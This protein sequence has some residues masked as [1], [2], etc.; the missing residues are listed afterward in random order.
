M[1]YILSVILG[2]ML[3]FGTAIAVTLLTQ[4]VPVVTA[5]SIISTTCIDGAHPLTLSPTGYIEGQTTYIRMTCTVDSKGY[6]AKGAI[7]GTPTF[8]LPSQITQLWSYT[9]GT[10][11]GACSAATGAWQMTSGSPHTFPSGTTTWDYCGV[12]PNTATG[13]TPGTFTV[14]WS[15]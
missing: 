10:L 8:T 11:S 5:Q 4:T 6:T 12:I 14:V 7:V 15:A 2:S 3:I 9:A 1:A 13:D